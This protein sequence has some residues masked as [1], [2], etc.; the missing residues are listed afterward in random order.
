M[1]LIKFILLLVCSSSATYA[2][3]RFAAESYL[4]SPEKY[5]G[6]N[7]TVYV[8]EVR[9]PAINSMTDDPFRVFWIYTKGR[10]A[11]EYVWGGGIYVKVAKAQ[12]DAFAKRHNNPNKQAPANLSG[13]FSEWPTEYGPNGLKDRH[14]QEQ[15]WRSACYSYSKFY[16]DCTD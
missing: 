12:A 3:A 7:V 8:D 15:V 5:L 14:T 4:A 6:K 9:V 16:L 13:K 2:Q 10:N 1:K 11:N